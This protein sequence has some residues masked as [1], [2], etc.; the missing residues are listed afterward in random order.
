[1]GCDK[2]ITDPNKNGV[3]LLAIP[4]DNQACVALYFDEAINNFTLN[5]GR[6]RVRFNCI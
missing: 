4:S 6:S 2:K 3:S 5:T 1:L